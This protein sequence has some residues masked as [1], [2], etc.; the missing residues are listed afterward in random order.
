MEMDL[1]H[2]I[3][4]IDVPAL[5]MVGDQDRMTPPSSSVALAGDLPRGRLQVIEG[6]GHFPMMERHEDFNERLAGFA[7]EVLTPRRGGRKRA[8][9]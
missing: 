8:R 3:E 5:V 7:A 4:H 1:R 6:A 9:T 2:A